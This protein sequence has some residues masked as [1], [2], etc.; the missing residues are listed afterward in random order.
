MEHQKI[1]VVR[2]YT[3]KKINIKPIKQSCSNS[4]GW[5]FKGFEIWEYQG[6]N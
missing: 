2:I 3:N 5:G 1:H 4:R 6:T